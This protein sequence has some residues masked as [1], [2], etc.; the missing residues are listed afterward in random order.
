M[1][2][3]S[4]V[5]LALA[6]LV[7]ASCN[8]GGG[9]IEP[10][11]TPWDGVSKTAPVAG[12]FEEDGVTYDVYTIN[13]AS[14]LAW[15]ADQVNSGAAGAS[16]MSI[17]LNN[18]IDLGNQEWTPIGYADFSALPSYP[19]TTETEYT[20]TP[21]F[22]GSIFGNGHTIMNV[23]L[24]SLVGPGRGIFGQI[25]GTVDS[26][27]VVK[28]VHAVN[29]SVNGDGKWAGGLIG[30]V[31]NVKEISGCSVKNVTIETGEGLTSSET[32]GSG[33]LVGM[34]SNNAEILI[35]NC[36]SENVTFGKT[37]WNNSGFIGKLWD[38][39][40]VTIQDCQPSMTIVRTYLYLDGTID[41][42]EYYLAPDG[43]NNSW[44]I[45][46]ITNRNGLELV[47]NNVA[48]NSMNW[49]EQDSNGSQGN[50][51]FDERDAA[52]AWPYITIFDRYTDNT[53][54]TI[55]VDG[56][57]IFPATQPQ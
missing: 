9:Q 24:E 32:F 56:V 36:S 5:L 37:G 52:F 43:Y 51:T 29:V 42:I 15:F 34:V 13:E 16:T 1:K 22:Q 23:N 48:N 38:N 50:I 28:D 25:I 47:I 57:Q 6:G 55:T 39:K 40:K 20:A 14:E 7:F 4:L 2:K 21:L 3:V 10:P 17:I 26:P 18:D 35:S 12:T 8:E 46:N 54:A 31:R 11:V 49:I 19:R 27:S 30:Y 53:T 33:A 41:G 44:F 45:G